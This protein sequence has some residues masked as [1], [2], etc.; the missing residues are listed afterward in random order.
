[1]EITLRKYCSQVLTNICIHFTVH[2][3]VFEKTLF[4]I[5]FYNTVAYDLNKR[6]DKTRG[7]LTGL[8]LMIG[9]VVHF[10]FATLLPWVR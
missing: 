1:M 6:N 7:L 8:S 3:K 2:M 10:M 4:K 5:C 9:L